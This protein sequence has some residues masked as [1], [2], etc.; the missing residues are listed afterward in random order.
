MADC[1]HCGGCTNEVGP[2]MDWTKTGDCWTTTGGNAVVMLQAYSI[3]EHQG[4]SLKIEINHPNGKR[5]SDII[6]N[7]PYHVA[8]EVTND[9]FGDK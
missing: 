9:L 4:M 2:V 6:V 8:L 1:N 5:K 7:I 3:G